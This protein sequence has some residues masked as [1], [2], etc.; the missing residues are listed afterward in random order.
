MVRKFGVGGPFPDRGI[1][2]CF[3]RLVGGGSYGG[4]Q[5]AV[6][7]CFHGD[8]GIAGVDGPLEPP[9]AFGAHDVAQLAHAKERRNPRHQVL[10]EG[11][12]R[13]EDVSVIGS[14]LT[15]LGCGDRRQGGF[16]RRMIDPDDAGHSRE[17]RRLCCNCAAVAG[18]HGNVDGRWFETSGAGHAFRRAGI[19]GLPV[20]LGND[21]HPGHQ[22][23]SFCR[24]A[25]TNSATSCTLTPLGRWAGGSTASTR[26]WTFGS[27]SRSARVSVSNGFFLALRMSGSFV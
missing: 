12:R 16:V 11:G 27:T 22:I 18:E 25:C 24:S 15:N 9:G 6:R 4:H 7:R 23:N 26:N 3:G 19:E 10:A 8:N 14:Q 13:A 20:M 2:G 17:C 1:A 5:G 21:Q